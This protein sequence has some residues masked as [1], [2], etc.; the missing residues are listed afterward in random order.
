MAN[1]PTRTVTKVTAVHLGA[2]VKRLR[3]ERNIRQGDLAEA[4]GFEKSNVSRFENGRQQL[5]PEQLQMV[6]QKLGLSLTELIARAEGR[7]I[8]D[9]SAL[10]GSL[11]R[12]VASLVGGLESGRL[13]PTQFRH[14][15][16]LLFP[17]RSASLSPHD[18]A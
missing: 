18:S 15:L 14:A 13:S 1:E 4:I 5:G 11:H 16:S 2:V 3:R 10:D 6:A 17:E 7:V 9:T 12:D 8:V